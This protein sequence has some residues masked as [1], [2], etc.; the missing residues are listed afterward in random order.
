MTLEEF[1]RNK[2][3]ELHPTHHRTSLEYDVYREDVEPNYKEFL[4]CNCSWL[5]KVGVLAFIDGNKWDFCRL[6]IGCT[7]A[8]DNNNFIGELTFDDGENMDLGR[9][10]SR[11]VKTMIKIDDIFEEDA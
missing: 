1:L 10:L 2:A 9:L 7:D 5:H 6:F 4:E 8:C 3:D 11:I